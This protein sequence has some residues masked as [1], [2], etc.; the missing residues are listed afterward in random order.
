METP[1]IA[2]GNGFAFTNAQELSNWA[3]LAIDWNLNPYRLPLL[4]DEVAALLKM[5]KT[6]RGDIEIRFCCSDPK[7]DISHQDE[8]LSDMSEKILQSC[9]EYIGEM[10]GG[11][12]T[13]GLHFISQDSWEQVTKKLKK[14]VDCG[15]KN[16]VVVCV[17]NISSG[18]LSEP[19][20]FKELLDKTGAMVTFGLF[21]GESSSEF[22]DLLKMVSD[23]I[24][25]A[26]LHNRT[27][28]KDSLKDIL[29]ALLET[30]CSWWSVDLS[31]IDEVKSSRELLG[32]FLKE[33]GYA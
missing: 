6:R 32:R 2:I 9:I 18:P 5:A 11:Y 22:L 28:S 3:N 14:L 7:I 26:H 4:K 17:E 27:F 15:N 8:R 29:D 24:V 19:K 13:I 1:K 33:K 10:G 20:R 25:N 16:G 30:G 31:G 12:F 21:N 23:R